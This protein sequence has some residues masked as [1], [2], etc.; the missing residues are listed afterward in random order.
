MGFSLNE[1]LQVLPAH[2]REG[3]KSRSSDLGVWATLG[4]SVLL[5]VVTP[6][7]QG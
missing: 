5:V 1:I 3:L 7:L 6:L 2:H 4:Q